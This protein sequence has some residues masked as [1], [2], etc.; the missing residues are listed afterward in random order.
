MLKYGTI[1]A[2]L[3]GAVSGLAD[4]TIGRDGGA[5]FISLFLPILFAFEFFIFFSAAWTP[6]LVIALL[7]RPKNLSGDEFRLF[8]AVLA[9]SCVLFFCAAYAFLQRFHIWGF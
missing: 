8:L 7:F 3:V 5:G 1:A 9:G 6:C 4:M 2:A